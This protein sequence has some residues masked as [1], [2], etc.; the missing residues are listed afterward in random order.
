MPFLFFCA[1]SCFSWPTISWLI[2]NERRNAMSLKFC[3]TKLVA[4]VALATGLAVI[5]TRSGSAQEADVWIEAPGPARVQP[6]IEA[7]DVIKLKADAVKMATDG[8]Q[9]KIMALHLASPD[10]THEIRRAATA[11]NEAE[12]GDARDEAKEKLTGLLDEYFEADM[13]RREKELAEVEERVTKLRSTLQRR[14]EKKRDIVD[15]QMEVLLNEADGLGFFGSEGFGGPGSP[16]AIHQGPPGISVPPAPPRA[17]VAPAQPK[18]APGG[19]GR[20]GGG[21]GRGGFGGFGGGRGDGGDGGGSPRE[22]E[23]RGRNRERERDR[24]REPE[25]ETESEEAPR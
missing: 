17:V 12:G 22:T 5:A 24:D 6:K 18:P 15:L 1:F 20:G 14:R 11:L 9:K 4:G 19:F 2:Q 21:F 25:W 7:L 16:W 13:E 10:K 8:V 3:G 23:E